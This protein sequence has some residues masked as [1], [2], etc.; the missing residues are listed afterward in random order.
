MQWG[1]G[2]RTKSQ[3]QQFKLLLA[4]HSNYSNTLPLQKRIKEY[5]MTGGGGGEGL[6]A[7]SEKL[8]FFF[9]GKLDPL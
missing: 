9:F 6:N 5:S 8:G 7:V 2:W 1:A 4:K 3:E